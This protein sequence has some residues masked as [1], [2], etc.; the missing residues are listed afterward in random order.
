VPLSPAP[1]SLG[2]S[3]ASQCRLPPGFVCRLLALVSQGDA[4][5]T[6]AIADAP[7]ARQQAQI[8]ASVHSQEKWRLALTL[9]RQAGAAAPIV[10]AVLTD[11][12]S[13]T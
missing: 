1:T 13:E 3:G 9:L 4:V 8:P 5:S 10:T 2:D 12:D 11:A 7:A 6:R